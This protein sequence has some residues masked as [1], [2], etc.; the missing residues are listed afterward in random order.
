MNLQQSGSSFL[1]TTLFRIRC[2]CKRPKKPFAH[3]P[4]QLALLE[5]HVFLDRI[6]SSRRPF[7]WGPTVNLIVRRIQDGVEFE[8]YFS[9][10][11]GGEDVDFAL[12]KRD[13]WVSQ[14]GQGFHAAPG[15]RAMDE[16]G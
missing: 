4:T 13:Y 14:G 16:R 12:R 10:L 8:D 2:Y 9:T 1:T 7:T 5:A 11:G 6:Q 3:A 15:V